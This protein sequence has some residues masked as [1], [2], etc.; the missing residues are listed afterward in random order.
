MTEGP[1]PSLDRVLSKCR[2]L[3]EVGVSLHWLRPRDKMPI[4][5]S[6]SEAATH[7]LHSFKRTHTAGANVGVRL[8]QKSRTALGFLHLIDLDIRDESK[9]AKALGALRL[10]WPGFEDAPTVQSGSGG[11]SRHLYFLTETPYRSKKLMFS[12]GSSMVFDTRLGREVK[13]NDWEIELFGTGKQAVLPPSIHP[14]T[15]KEYL[16]LRPLD[17]DDLDMLLPTPLVNAWGADI[18]DREDD[19]SDFDLEDLL[20]REPLDLSQDEIDGYLEDLPDSWVDDR[21]QW[22]SVGMM[23]HHQFRGSQEGYDIWCAWSQQ[24]DKFNAKDSRAVWRSFKGNRNPQTMKSLIAAAKQERAVQR[25]GEID[26]IEDGE[27]ISETPPCPF[28]D[29]DDLS[30]LFG[31]LIEGTATA[32]TPAADDILGPKVADD[33]KDWK[34]DLQ[35]TEEGA[36]IS[37][38]PNLGLIVANDVRLQGIVGFNEFMQ[39][40]C[41]IR[42]PQRIKARANANKS[43]GNLDSHIWTVSNDVGGDRWSEAHR[44]GLREILEMTESRKGYGIKVSDR[45]LVAAVE[46][47]AHRAPYHPVR[48][49]LLDCER[50]DDGRRGLVEGFYPTYLKTGD[51]AYFHQ[52]GI[53]TFVDAIARVFE[54][55]CKYDYV[56]ILEGNQGIGKSTMI[57]IMGMG[58]KGDLEGDLSE[59]KKI[60]EMLAG[61]WI[62]EIPELSSFQKADIET[63]KSKITLT[64]DTARMSYAREPQDFKRQCIWM[65]STNGKAYLRDPTGNRR[66]WPIPCWNVVGHIDHAGLRANIRQMWAEAM[67]IY[68]QMRRDKPHGSGDLDFSPKAEVA[69]QAIEMQESRRSETLADHVHAEVEEWLDRPIG[70]PPS[71]DAFDNLH[72]AGPPRYRMETCVMEILRKLYERSQGDPDRG[73]STLVGNVLSQIKGWEREPKRRTMKDYG[74]VW[75]YRRTGPVPQIAQLPAP[76]DD[77]D[78]LLG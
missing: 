43:A 19:D 7:D 64:T 31:D 47:V 20:K 2:S 14:V 55:G 26:E 10:I 25:R 53:N 68:R 4:A 37:N 21:D 39:T 51:S 5:T 50:N 29:L 52:M 76:A 62:L 36:T 42:S 75:V 16:W 6:W 33:G 70:P 30:D 44:N 54:P 65:G 48:N 49:L 60:V 72:E 46:N 27:I 17:L 74:R 3:V 1:S 40:T 32:V 8:G 9:A 15:G 22:C 78:D 11:S 34:T 13:R 38:L 59:S 66:F 23:L 77:L 28:D 45:D 12:A 63:L 71:A 67:A 73:F 57:D 41:L 58:F 18:D 24:S 61:K 56:I 35:L 69:A